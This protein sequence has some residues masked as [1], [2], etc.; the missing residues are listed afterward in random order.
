MVTMSDDVAPGG[1]GRR[2]VL[3]GVGVVGVAA[4]AGCA[5]GDDKPAGLA[6]SMKGKEI[7]K[8]ADV[9]VGGGKILADIKVVVTQPTQGT[10]KAFTAVCTHQGCLTGKVA[11]GLV[12]C[13]CHGSEFK[14]ADGS[15][16]RGPA[17]KPLQE[18]PVQVKGDGIV[19][20]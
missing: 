4:L 15:V 12:Q 7:A 20:I 3:C 14:I 9:P 19:L 18:Y 13:P 2:T 10:F 6:P 16:A 5:G 17:A 1:F 11:G 8:T